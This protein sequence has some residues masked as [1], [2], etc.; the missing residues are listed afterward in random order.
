MKMMILKA[1]CIVLVCS[2]L[3]SCGCGSGSRLS[4]ETHVFNVNMKIVAIN[5]ESS[6]SDNKFHTPQ[7][8]NT[9]LFVTLTEPKLYREINTCNERSI[10]TGDFHIESEWFYNHRIGDTVHFDHLLKSRFFTIA[11]R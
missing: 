10:Q 5:H 3:W 11:E 2:S 7:L 1:L 8:C 9:I 4:E 6:L